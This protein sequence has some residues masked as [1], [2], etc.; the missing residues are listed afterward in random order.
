MADKKGPII[1]LVG[2]NTVYLNKGEVYV[3]PGYMASDEVDGD[4]S[5]DVTV[6]GSVD[7]SKLGTY[8]LRYNVS[9]SKY[10]F[11]GWYKDPI[12]KEICFSQF[13]G[14]MAELV[15]F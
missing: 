2:E 14:K 15:R 5:G 8:L 9:D 13:K 11:A 6:T 7:K 10:I 12:K 4:T 1:S 3:E